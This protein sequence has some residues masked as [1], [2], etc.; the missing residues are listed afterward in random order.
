[1]TPALTVIIPV[2]DDR[3]MVNAI[4]SAAGDNVE[5]LVVF[6]D[7]FHGTLQQEAVAAGATF[8]VANSTNLAVVR[9]I[10]ISQAKSDQ[11]LFLDSDCR[12][13]IGTLDWVMLELARSAVAK[14]L[15]EY[16]TV[17]WQTRITSCVREFT[18]TKTHL[19][20]LPLAFKKEIVS[21]IGGYYFDERLGWGEDWDFAVRLLGAFPGLK[22]S[23][24]AN[25]I[26]EPLTFGA[27]LR[28]AFRIGMGRSL[29]V[30]NGL[31]R[32]RVIFRDLCMCGELEKF[33]RVRK[34]HGL[35]AGLYHSF[36]WR[37]AYKAGYYW[38]RSS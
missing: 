35:I 11:V 2:K 22:P 33:N 13:D 10:G 1:M 4:T 24:E 19:P 25:I 15:L 8:V 27:D 12:L 29:Q 3:L 38:T 16:K 14:P 28:S 18:T 7:N 17:S 36:G 37:L 30:N 9:N 20:L 34:M 21:S 6:N 26:H 31:H 5:V 23:P 32:R